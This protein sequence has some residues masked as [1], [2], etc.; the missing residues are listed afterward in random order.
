MID[1]QWCVCEGRDEPVQM[2]GQGCSQI[3]W[4]MQVMRQVERHESRA[5]FREADIC[6][7]AVSYL[8]PRAP[9]PES[10]RC[11]CLN[12]RCW[13][14]VETCCVAVWLKSISWL[15]AGFSASVRDLTSHPELVKETGGGCETGESV[16]LNYNACLFV[17]V[18]DAQRD[19]DSMVVD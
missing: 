17:W 14:S 4:Q 5:A 16:R 2:D 15:Q 12:D 7:P 1:L 3:S 11:L 6:E 19:G 8:L 18:K 13:Q 10:N 9:R